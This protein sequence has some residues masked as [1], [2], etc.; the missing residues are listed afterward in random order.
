M[1]HFDSIYFFNLVKRFYKDEK[2][3]YTVITGLLSFP[4]IVL[5][6]VTIES[7]G[8]LLDKARLSQG[9]DQAALALIAENNKYR[10]NKSHSEVTRQVVT[11]DE[12]N[13]FFGDSFRAQQDK[14]NQELIQGMSKLYMRSTDNQVDSPFTV[15][16]N[17]K[18]N[19]DEIDIPTNN[20]YAIRKPVV[21]EVQGVMNRKYLFSLSEKLI[22][23]DNSGRLKMDSGRSYAIKEKGI[24]IPVELMLV[25]DF[26]GS[27]HQDLNGVYSSDKT[28]MGK[29][30]ISILREVVNEISQILLPKNISDEI[31]PYNRMGFTTFSGGVRQ[32]GEIKGCILPY[33]SKNSSNPQRLT[34]ERWI[35]GNN[36]PPVWN[37]TTRQWQTDWV[38]FEDW[39]AGRYQ[40]FYSSSCIVSGDKQYCT[41]YA[42]P[43]T[44]MD[45]AFEIKDWTTI[46]IIFNHYMGITETINQISRFDGSNRD[47]K[48]AFEDSNYCLG[49]NQNR[50][51]T[52]AWFDQKNK[53]ISK[54]LD[55]VYPQGWTSA[56][57]GLIVGA[58]LIMDNNK[59]EGAKPALLGTNT[60]RVLLVLS[61]G[62]DNWP[63]YDTL[64]TLLNAGICDKIRER[65]NSLQDSNFKQLPTRIAFVAFGYKP[66]HR[67]VEAWKRCV[68]DQYYVAYSQKEL[69]DTFKQIIGFEEE[70]GRS[71][72][73][74][75]K[76]N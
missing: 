2:G 20:N 57:S 60:Q 63:N 27:M 58:N 40:Q 33:E 51:T 72:P 29:S 53:D 25:A 74:K 28:R 31:S 70:V 76:F 52:Q 65:V 18:Y 56:S 35:T 11:R 19:C 50:Q 54:Q 44:I 43:K 55:R 67:Q 45:Y 17:F 34:I 49:N 66:P 61:D 73:N 36:V 69:L 23:G 59:D 15:D 3:V 68:G 48:L 16:T 47:Y 30:K 22:G 38:E 12:V 64:V 75:P 41:I 8:L 13:N 26:S 39:Y 24:V 37:N 10:E 71:L 9:M 7:T 21:C 5:I 46:R 1:K 14:R 32:K 42:N 6:A 62:E 4:L